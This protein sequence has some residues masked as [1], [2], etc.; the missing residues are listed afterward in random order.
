MATLW[1]IPEKVNTHWNF[2]VRFSKLAPPSFTPIFFL[3]L[4]FIPVLSVPPPGVN[5]RKAMVFICRVNCWISKTWCLVQDSTNICWISELLSRG[6]TS[7]PSLFPGWQHAGYQTQG[8][9][10]QPGSPSR[11]S[12]CLCLLKASKVSLFVTVILRD[13][14]VPIGHRYLNLGF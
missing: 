12:N 7:K 1:M 3:A 9:S 4:L 2:F 8:G 14:I 11:V 13:S 10:V 6:R 5:S